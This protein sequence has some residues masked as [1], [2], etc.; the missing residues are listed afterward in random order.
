MS[1]VIVT[2]GRNKKNKIVKKVKRG[3]TIPVA[4]N[5]LSNDEVYLLKITELKQK[6][7]AWERE[8]LSLQAQIEAFKSMLSDARSAVT[9]KKTKKTQ[10]ASIIDIISIDKILKKENKARILCCGDVGGSV[11]D[12]T[13]NLPVDDLIKIIKEAKHG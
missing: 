2:D 6:N 12:I 5:L 10:K 4:V 9:S 7:E 1:K 3:D 13:I 8:V 11:I